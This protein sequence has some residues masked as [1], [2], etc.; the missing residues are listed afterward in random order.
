VDYLRTTVKNLRKKI[1]INPE[2][3]Q[4]VMTEPWIGYRFN[5]AP[6]PE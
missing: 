4:Y 6:E 2:E 1:E 5:G 3:P